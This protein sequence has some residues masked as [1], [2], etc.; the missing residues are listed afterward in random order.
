[1]IVRLAFKAEAAAEEQC[2]QL[3]TAMSIVLP[4]GRSTVIGRNDLRDHFGDDKM[5]HQRHA[6]F[7]PD[8]NGK[9]AVPYRAVPHLLKESK[10]KKRALCHVYDRTAAWRANPAYKMH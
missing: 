4:A 5:I 10:Q 7:T 6:S 3:Q 2:P 1:M 8:E 9:T